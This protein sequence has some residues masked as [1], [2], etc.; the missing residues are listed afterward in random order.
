VNFRPVI[1]SFVTVRKSWRWTQW[2]LVFFAIF[3]FLLTLF[4]HE[5]YKKTLLLRRLKKRGLPPPP[6]PFPS[7]A[8][9]LKFFLTVTVLRPIHMLVTEP[10]VGVF[11]LYVAFNFAVLYAFFAA[12]PLVFESVYGFDAEQ[13]GLVFLAIGVGCLLAVPT[14]ILCDIY[15]YQPRFRASKAAGKAGVVAPE[16]RLY[17][18]M[19]GSVGLPLGLFVRSLFLPF[20]YEFADFMKVVCMDRQAR[21]LLGQPSRSSDTLRM[22]QPVH[23]RRSRKLLN[24]HIPSA[25]RCFCAS[26]KRTP[27]VHTR[28]CIPVVYLA[29]V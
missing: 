8:A 12:F 29:D 27:A 21:N 16:Y 18:A 2:V 3:S 13:T 15:L 5:T 19:M 28:C 9:K 22:G 7:T 11:S 6:S 25:E 10:I 26:S 1:G 23:L 24:R 17:P 14:V 20:L 4:T